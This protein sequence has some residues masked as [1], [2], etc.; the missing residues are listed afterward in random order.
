M[1]DSVEP[2]VAMTSPMPGQPGER[3]RVGSG[4]DP[5][6]HHLGQAAGHQPGLAVVAEAEAV[7]GA[8]RDGHDVLE[9]AAQLDAED[10]AVHVEP[11]LAATEPV[12]DAGRELGVVGGHDRR[13]R[14]AAGDLGGEV[15]PGQGGD[16]RRRD[17]RRPRR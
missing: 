15:R 16:A 1:R 14:Q 6:P 12:G 13:G 10:V 3:Q 9:R 11:E 4:R 5:E 8:R 2:H 17:A 7:G